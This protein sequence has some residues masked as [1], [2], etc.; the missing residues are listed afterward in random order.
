VTINIAVAVVEGLVM[1]ADSFSQMAIDGGGV[2]ATHSSVEKIT[3]IGDRQ[4]AVMINGLGS[5]SNRTIL[6]L[7]REFEFTEYSRDPAPI[8][9]WTVVELAEN[10]GQFIGNR[11]A[12]QYPTPPVGE[13]DRRPTLGLVVGGYSPGKFFPEV[14]EIQF[15]DQDCT[16]RWPDDPND[17]PF[18]GWFVDFWGIRKSLKRLLFGFDLESLR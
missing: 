13:R 5:I 4:I 7:L 3:E 12:A 18:G 14:V 10:L 17:E 9:T 8:K 11:Y 2:L 15:P 1:A 6:S 16:R